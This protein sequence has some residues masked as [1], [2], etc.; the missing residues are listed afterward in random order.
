MINYYFFQFI[1]KKRIGPD[2]PVRPPGVNGG[3]DSVFLNLDHIESDH[4]D[5]AGPWTARIWTGSDR[6][7]I[8]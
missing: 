3:T 4:M 8:S 2:G 5:R 7:Q 1:K 6:L